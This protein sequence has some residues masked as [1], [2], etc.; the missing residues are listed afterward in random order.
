MKRAL[1]LALLAGFGFVLLATPASA[2]A[3]VLRSD[4]ANGSDLPQ[5][6]TQVV[7]T[8]TEPINGQK[9]SIT[10]QV[11]F[12]Q[13]GPQPAPTVPPASQTQNLLSLTGGNP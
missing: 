10:T 12:V 3:L 1:A 5:S 13:Y 7:I 6:P 9:A 8:Y 4:P 11:D 2:H